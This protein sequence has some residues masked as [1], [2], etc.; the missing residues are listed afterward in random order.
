[1]NL[2]TSCT[3]MVTYSQVV[4]LHFSCVVMQLIKSSNL[5]FRLLV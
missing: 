1:M 2:D 3:V 5:D 4:K